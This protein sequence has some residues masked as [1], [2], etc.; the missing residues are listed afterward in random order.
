[1]DQAPASASAEAFLGGVGVGQ[2]PFFFGENFQNRCRVVAGPQ[3][4][5]RDCAIREATTAGTAKMLGLAIIVLFLILVGA[6][7]VAEPRG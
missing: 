3:V 7:I 4:A 6:R 2:A 1:V 5:H